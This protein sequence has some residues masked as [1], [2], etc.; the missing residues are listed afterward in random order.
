MGD[1]FPH[2]FIVLRIS[3]ADLYPEFHA[4]CDHRIFTIFGSIPI[5]L[6]MG[7]FVGIYN[8]NSTSHH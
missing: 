2:F 1:S 7:L 8:Q 4:S 5:T 3:N 6:E